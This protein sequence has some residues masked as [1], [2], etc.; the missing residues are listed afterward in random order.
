MSK[1]F[2]IFQPPIKIILCIYVCFILIYCT[3]AFKVFIHH[4]VK[5]KDDWLSNYLRLEM[6][7]H[8]TGNIYIMSTQ[9]NAALVCKRDVLNLIRY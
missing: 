7:T 9:N 1:P 5:I 3:P 8:V 6:S 2:H 4:A